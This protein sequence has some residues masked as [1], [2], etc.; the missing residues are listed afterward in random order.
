MLKLFRLLFIAILLGSCL[1][2]S[3]IDWKTWQ[4][5]DIRITS[6]PKDS[7]YATLMVRSLSQRINAFQMK[8]GVYPVRPLVIT[9]LP[10]RQEY[11]SLTTGK[12]KIVESSQ[13]FYSPSERIIY[14][15]SPDQLAMESY[16]RVLM[17]EYIHWF[18]DETMSGVPLWFHEGMAFYYSGQFGFPAYYSF[19]QYRFLGYKLSLSEMAHQYPR[20]KSYWTM[21]YLTSA[22]AVHHL[23][24]KRHDQWIGFWDRVGVIYSISSGNEPYKSDFAQTFYSAF[25]ISQYAFSLEFDKVLNRYGWQFPLLGINGLIFSLLPFVIL[26]AWLRHRRHL[27]AM[28]EAVSEDIPEPEPSDSPEQDDTSPPAS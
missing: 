25:R 9:I 13:A 11:E 14:V 7:A 4:Y 3:A 27:K 10:N 12:G 19:T 22:F 8:L 28:P 2:L 18:L 16:D 26:I 15:R 6:A 21:F 17:H 23:Q 24:S 20:Q 1:T 5:N